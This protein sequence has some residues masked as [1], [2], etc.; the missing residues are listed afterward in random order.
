[1]AK[2]AAISVRVDPEFR[3]QIEAEA[4]KDGRTLAAYV[5]RVLQ[6]HLMMPQWVLRDP[7]PISRRDGPA[8]LLTV[9]EGWPSVTLSADR[10]VAL[11]KQLQY[12]A[13]VARG[14]PPSD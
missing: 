1:M 6:L 4:T 10:A 11:A 8:V 12:A 3:D 9:A 7:Q 5:E 14:M 13:D 2:T